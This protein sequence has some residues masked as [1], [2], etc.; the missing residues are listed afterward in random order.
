MEQVNYRYPD[1]GDDV[2][3]NVSVRIEAGRRVAVVGETGSGKTTFA[4]LITRLF[5]PTEG[6]V[7]V[8]GIPVN[9]VRSRLAPLPCGIR[10]ARGLPLRRL[11]G[12]QRALRTSRL[13]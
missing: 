5:D 8:G 2:L 11:G 7:V 4:K 12:G 6:E 9:R 13:E 1:G 10:A 3:Q